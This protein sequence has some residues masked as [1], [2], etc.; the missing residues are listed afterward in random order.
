MLRIEGKARVFVRFIGAKFVPNNLLAGIP[1]I[2]PRF[3]AKRSLKYVISSIFSPE[4]F[5]VGKHLNRLERIEFPLH[6]KK[7]EKR[8]FKRLVKCFYFDRNMNYSDL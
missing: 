8:C 1:R 2:V 4:P 5:R 3:P 6:K 7:M